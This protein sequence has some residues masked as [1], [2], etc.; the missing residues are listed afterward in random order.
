MK[1]LISVD[2]EGLP[3]I[4]S[5]AQLAPKRPLYDEA[6]RIMTKLVCYVAN[7]LKDLKIEEIYVGDSH[8]FMTNIIYDELPSGVKLVS[9]FPRPFSMVA[10]ANKFK[11]D[12]A[13]L[14]GY[15]NAFG[16]PQAI[17]DH[18]YSGRVFRSV[19]ING[20]DVAEFDFNTYLLGEF[21]VPVILV[22]GDASLEERAKKLTPW[23][24]F[25][26]F[27]SS[28]SRYS[29]INFPLNEILISLNKGLN[30]AIKKLEEREPKPVTPKKPI[31]FELT[32]NSTG[33]ADL[34]ELIPGAQRTDGT[35]VVFK[36]ESMVEAFKILEISTLLG[37]GLDYINQM[38]R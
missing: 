8:G 14:L 4:V 24:P 10:P 2:L 38:L 36:L 15:H 12:G 37:A 35:T 28:L 17:F 23:A 5:T 11:F 32:L 9:G 26:P 6:R 31:I 3:G 21:N 27:K 1:L 7:T 16:T 20:V 33:Y 22:A 30:E 13:I 25:I 19:K 18:T 34:V 29:A